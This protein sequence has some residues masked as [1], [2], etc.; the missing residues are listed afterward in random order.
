MAG[1]INSIASYHPILSSA[2]I[3]YY[4]DAMKEMEISRTE[5]KTFKA[6][7]KA[8]RPH[9]VGKAISHRYAVKDGVNPHFKTYL[10][11]FLP[12]LTFQQKKPV[13]MFHMGNGGGSCLLRSTSPQQLAN[14]L[15][16]MV[17]ILRSDIWLDMFQE[18]EFISDNLIESGGI[19]LDEKFVDSGAFKKEAGLKENETFPFIEVRQ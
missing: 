3:L 5:I 12:K 7:I 11:T 4:C 8:T 16:H 13:A 14:E 18:L 1:V 6:R 19:I 9:W 2:N 17:E 15:E 10:T